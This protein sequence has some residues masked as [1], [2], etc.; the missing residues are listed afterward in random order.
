MLYEKY[1]PAKFQDLVG[2]EYTSSILKNQISTCKIAHS[3]LFCGTRGT[4]K[5][6]SARIFAKAINCTNPKN[7]DPCGECPSCKAIENRKSMDVIELDAASH[8]GVD[9]IREITNQMQYAPAQGKYKIFII[10]E[11]HM[12]SKSAVNAFLKSLEEPPNHV[13]FILATTDPQQLPITIISRCQRFDFKR[14]SVNKIIL[15]LKTVLLEEHQALDDDILELIAKTA[16]GAMRDAL[17]VL[18]KILSLKENDRTI[19]NISKLL[20]M[21]GFELINKLVQNIISYNI[22]NT[23]SLLNALDNEGQDFSVLIK[24]MI[25]YVRNLMI[26]SSNGPESIIA[27]TREDIE[28]MKQIVVNTTT[29]K[30]IELLELLQSAE[31]NIKW[32]GNSKVALETVA[33]KFQQYKEDDI[34]KELQELKNMILRLQSIPAAI[35]PNIPQESPNPNKPNPVALA[36]KQVVDMS[37]KY[38]KNDFAAALD[39]SKIFMKDNILLFQ[40]NSSENK[41]ILETNKNN[42][43][44]GFSKYLQRELV[45]EIK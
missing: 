2:Q 23:L 26:L 22:F 28:N 19:D 44:K 40:S 21:N 6:T 41:N 32:N 4:G 3:Y 36:K 30:T 16:D 5:T 8:N 39:T 11:A 15:R 38:N 34:S 45:I 20:S 37:A 17:S 13:V 27:A 18:E 10:D 12:L 14:I 42:L 43:I 25:K 29:D 31:N 24:D 35:K 7:G 9:D 33:I 1:R